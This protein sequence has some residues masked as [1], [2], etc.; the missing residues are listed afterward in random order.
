[1]A[2]WSLWAERDLLRNVLA[3]RESTI[4]DL[5]DEIA[6]LEDNVST[7]T[8]AKQE[9]TDQLNESGKRITQ[10][11]G[12]LDREK[13]ENNT[14]RRE[15]ENWQRM[16]FTRIT[17][18][19]EA[20]KR[21]PK[22]WNGLALLNNNEDKERTP[23]VLHLPAEALA[24]AQLAYDHF[25]DL[26]SPVEIGLGNNRVA[27][28]LV[29]F[30]VMKSESI[31]TPQIDGE[32][33]DAST[34]YENETHYV[35]SQ[36]R[37]WTFFAYTGQVIDVETINLGE[38]AA[39]IFQIAEMYLTEGEVHFKW[40][41]PTTR[42]TV[43]TVNAWDELRNRILLS[44]LR[45]VVDGDTRREVILWQPLKLNANSPWVFIEE[46]LWRFSLGGRS[47]IDMLGLRPNNL[48]SAMQGFQDAKPLKPQHLHTILE[49]YEA[50]YLKHPSP[51]NNG[52]L[53]LMT[54]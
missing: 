19:E 53:P 35:D 20:E 30:P 45:I 26:Q 18:E 44:K 7:L 48:T 40:T 52:E 10:Q 24:K 38:R 39:E 36:R 29:A 47:R 5:D 33:G 17:A 3:D 12:E 1:M 37:H 49:F 32:D 41:A 9:L 4:D 13:N 21:K 15:N 43:M 50:L 34:E 42:P 2:Y 51:G 16:D 46:P 54:R 31:P 11:Q 22:T 28:R 27:Y 14:L 23:F 6:T 8:S 25:V